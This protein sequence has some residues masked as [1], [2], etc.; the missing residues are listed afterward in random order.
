MRKKSVLAVGILF[1]RP[2]LQLPALTRFT[3]GDGPIFAGNIFPFC[4]ITIAC[5]AISGFHSLISSGTTPKPLARNVMPTNSTARSAAITDRS[6]VMPVIAN[7]PI[8]TNGSC[9]TATIAPTEN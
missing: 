9:S 8:T 4:F 2:D 6:K 3:D 5:G 1:V 7:Q